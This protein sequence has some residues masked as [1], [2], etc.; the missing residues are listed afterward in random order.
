MPTPQSHTNLRT[1]LNPNQP[2]LKLTTPN[3]KK[4]PQLP[5]ESLQ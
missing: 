4:S 5:S 2:I 1:F 3:P